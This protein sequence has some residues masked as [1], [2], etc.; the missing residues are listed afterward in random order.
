VRLQPLLPRRA[1][2]R[3]VDLAT[4][5]SA[6]LLPHRDRLPGV[7]MGPAPGQRPALSRVH[8]PVLD[9]GFFNVPPGIGNSFMSVLSLLLTLAVTSAPPED[10]PF[11]AIVVGATGTPESAS[12]F[13]KAAD[14]WKAAAT[15]GGADAILI[16]TSA[17]AEGSSDRDRLRAVLNE[18]ASTS[19]EPVW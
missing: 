3:A 14:L 1:D 2:Q 15:R 19:T 18:R 5:A 17:P 12:A 9:L 13:H 11:V 10:R 6:L 4:L 16:G 7:G 8:G